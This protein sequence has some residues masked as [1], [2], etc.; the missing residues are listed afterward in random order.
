ML[1]YKIYINDALEMIRR[2]ESFEVN[3]RNL[4]DW[5]S[6][7]MRLQVIGESVKKIPRDLKKKYPD[8]EWSKFEDLRNF[9]SHVYM[10]VPARAISGIIKNDL[11]ELKDVLGRM[12]NEE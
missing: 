12:N 9:I 5:D 11:P 2:I 6:T 3:L 4:R 1:K 8:V 10:K 7:L